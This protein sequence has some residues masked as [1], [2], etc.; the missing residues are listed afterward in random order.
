MISQVLHEVSRSD[1]LAVL[2]DTN[3][4][5]VET[6]NYMCWYS[7]MIITAMHFSYPCRDVDKSIQLVMLEFSVIV[8]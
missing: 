5:G 6:W 7:G 2:L 1:D 3:T 4:P 8:T